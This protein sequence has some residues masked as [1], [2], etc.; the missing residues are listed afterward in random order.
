MMSLFFA[1][2]NHKSVVD[3]RNVF[4]IAS[5]RQGNEAAV[6][7]AVFYP[8]LDFFVSAVA[9]FIVYVGILLLKFADD[10]REVK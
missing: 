8:L 5:R 10:F 3:Y 9:Q 7:L 1:G 2:C 6:N 4:E